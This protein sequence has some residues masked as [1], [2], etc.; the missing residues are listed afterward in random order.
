VEWK[1]FARELE[2]TKKDR[3]GFLSL[4]VLLLISLFLPG[5]IEDYY[6][7]RRKPDT[8]TAWIAELEALM[9]DSSLEEPKTRSYPG[10]ERNRA[11]TPG[12]SKNPLT[13]FPFDPNVL[14]AEGWLELGLPDRT[15]KT[16]LNYRGKGGRFRKKED[17]AR[18]YGI[19]EEQFRVLEPYIEIAASAPFENREPFQKFERPERK[20]VI[21]DINLAD[22]S[23]FIALP[24][25]GSKLAGRVIAFREKLGGFDS[26]EQVK[27]V[28]G[29]ADSVFQKIRAFL[30]QGENNLRKINI[31]TATE[32]EL[33]AHPYIRYP[34]ARPIVAYR[35]THGPFKSVEDLKN[36]M[37]VTAEVFEKIKPYLSME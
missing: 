22:T 10:F 33:K 23:A 34:L 8:D 36:V 17:L 35:N 30:V 31:N 14:P 18:I 27:E 32:D 25:I 7:S 12:F 3:I 11:P 2:L 26:V 9:S 24:G 13:P 37:A 16:I 6:A 4:A 5:F 21:V 15:V 20:P 28:Y 19:T 1:K 29:L